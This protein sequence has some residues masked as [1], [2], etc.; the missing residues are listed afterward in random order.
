[1]VNLPLPDFQTQINYGHCSS[2]SSLVIVPPPLFNPTGGVTS[3]TLYDNFTAG[4]VAV[5]PDNAARY[6]DPTMYPPDQNTFIMAAQTGMNLGTDIR[7][8]QAFQL[9]PSSTNTTVTLTNSS[10]TLTY[11]VEPAIAASDRRT[12]RHGRA[13][14]RLGTAGHERAR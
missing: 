3:G 14:A 11:H 4:G 6:L 9:D 13:D 5:T 12:G 7:M 2:Q 10:T 1:M 8:M